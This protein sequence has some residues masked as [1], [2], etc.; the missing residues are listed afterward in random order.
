MVVIRKIHIAVLV[1]IVAQCVAAKETN[2][3]TFSPLFAYDP[4]FRSIF[5]VA[6]FSYPDEKRAAQGPKVFHQGTI[7]R[8]DDGH[9]KL[10]AIENRI[11]YGQ[12]KRKLILSMNNFFDYEFQEGSDE[13]ERY[14]RWQAS[15]DSKWSFPIARSTVWSWLYGMRLEVERH[16]R[17][18]H[19]TKGY[20]SIGLQRDRRDSVMH[21]RS[22]DIFSTRVSY[23]PSALY[24]KPIDDVAWSWQADYR[25]YHPV[26]FNS[27]LA[28]R[29]E[30]EKTDGDVFVSSLGGSSQLR[31]Y[32]DDRYEGKTKVAGQLELR[33]PIWKW[34]SGVTFIETGTL[35]VNSGWKT[36]TN[37]GGG[38]RFGLPPDGAIKIRVDYGVA[39][40]GD[41][42]VYVNFNQAF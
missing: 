18:G 34:V 26:M 28:S 30:V 17:D 41:S 21:T 13:Y 16:D 3:L 7:M 40:N 12:R 37:V 42:E 23:Q 6:L 29:L 25:Y 27:V 4:V 14:D 9:V 38:L 19:I 35:K 5:G 22:G 32:V 31:G 39:E 8:T 2:T 24:S 33:F 36:L 10:T 20:P 11:Y 15:I 1:M